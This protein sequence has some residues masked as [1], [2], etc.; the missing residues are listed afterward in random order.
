MDDRERA[1]LTPQVE[2]FGIRP[3]DRD[4]PIYK[5][6]PQ[7]G[8]R[9]RFYF[10]KTVV[11]IAIV[12]MGVGLSFVGYS[13]FGGIGWAWP[14]A[15]FFCVLT[16]PW[17]WLWLAATHNDKFVQP[18]NAQFEAAVEPSMSDRQE[19]ADRCLLILLGIKGCGFRGHLHIWEWNPGQ[20]I[21]LYIQGLQSLRKATVTKTPAS[22]MDVKAMQSELR[23]MGLDLGSKIFAILYWPWLLIRD[24]L[25]LSATAFGFIGLVHLVLRFL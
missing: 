15:L 9:L 16:W 17:F 18:I 14:P 24:L 3:P 4:D 25:A 19:V 1:N 23:Q 10:A 11:F 13:V 22:A 6:G 8:R 20:H 7:F 21:A 2:H 5:F 12:A